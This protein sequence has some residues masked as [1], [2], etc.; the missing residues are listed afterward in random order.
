MKA[1]DVNY[2]TRQILV[3]SKKAKRNKDTQAE[4]ILLR[5]VVLLEILAEALLVMEQQANGPSSC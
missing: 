3:L 4:E 2:L 1:E 5:A